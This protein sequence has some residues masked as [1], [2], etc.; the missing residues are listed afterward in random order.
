MMASFLLVHGSFCRRWIWRSTAAAL[1]AGGHRV[2]ALDLPSSGTDRT[3]LGGLQEDVDTVRRALEA[4]G[5]DVVLVGHS[6]GGLVL[7]ELAD[8]PAVRHSV[9]VASLRPQPGQSV[10]GMLGGQIPPWMA[11]SPEEGV[12]RVSDDPEVVRAA[13]CADVEKERF[14]RDV[15]P[16]YV[17]TAQKFFAD[18]CSAPTARHE[19]TYIICEQD[20]AVPV[21]VQQ[22]LAAS[23]DHV[24]RLP[25]SHS[26]LLSMPE[27][28]AQVL[29]SAAANG[30]P[31]SHAG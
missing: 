9:F 30:F 18:N 3:A 8:H 2:E 4:W 15:Y 28:L 12:V 10:E 26:V 25:S 29:E 16:R 7:V 31:P 20:Q 17:P 5:T 14:L 19:T 22:A 1:T 6:A 11:V 13:L 27:R 21:A 23:A 24:E